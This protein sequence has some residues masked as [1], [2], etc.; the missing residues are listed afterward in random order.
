MEKYSDIMEKDIRDN[1][2]PD[3]SKRFLDRSITTREV[4]F[5]LA[6]VFC[7]SPLITPPIALLMG[8]IIAQ[9]IGHPYLHLNHKATHILLQV[10][11][12]GL[13]FGMN[14]ASALKAGKEGVSFTVASILITLITGYFM[15]KSL[16]IDKKSA[17]LIS[18]GT[19]ICGG[20][21]IAAISP[22]IK[23]EEK[24][25]SVALGTIFILNAIALFFFPVIG[26]LFHL[27]QTQFGLWS[28][29]AI[30]DTSSVVGAAGKYGPEALEVATTVKLAR[31][32]WIIP[33]AFLSTFLFKNK[34]SKVKI[35]CFIGFFILAMIGNTSLPFVQH[36]SHYLTGIAKAGLTLTLFLIGCGLNRKLLM[37][38]GFRPM[39]QGTV[40]WAIIS[41]LALWAVMSFA[42]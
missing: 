41:V 27:S 31:A 6:T 10:S 29:I 24:Q 5:L 28:A 38:V 4:I 30:H 37:S 42:N 19:A 21:A 22:V 1:I 16:K 11:V 20:S 33:L 17:Y 7:L 39:I 36:I 34:D 23:A 3:C 25:I 40:L 18:A 8:L 13:G 26:H 12:V 35:P 9:F 32:L 2:Q 14:A 15:G